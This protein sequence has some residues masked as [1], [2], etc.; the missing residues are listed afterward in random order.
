[1]TKGSNE[2]YWDLEDALIE[3]YPAL[4]SQLTTAFSLLNNE[5]IY[6]ILGGWGHEWDD[7]P[8]ENARLVR[9]VSMLDTVTSNFTPNKYVNEEWNAIYIAN[10]EIVKAMM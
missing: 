2:E 10:H 1:M 8:N 5:T 7:N 6:P 9:L 4:E 3:S